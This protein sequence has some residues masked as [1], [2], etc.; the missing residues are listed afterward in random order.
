MA[1]RLPEQAERSSWDPDALA[2]LASRA[3]ARTGVRAVPPPPHD[4]GELETTLDGVRVVGRCRRSRRRLLQLLGVDVVLVPTLFVY[5]G[6]VVAAGRLGL[7]A[8]QPMI[9]AAGVGWTLLTL[10]MVSSAVLAAGLALSPATRAMTVRSRHLDLDGVRVAWEAV[11][12]VDELPDGLA[13][14]CADGRT[15][16]SP[17]LAP[18]EVRAIASLIAAHRSNPN[19]PRSGDRA[20][21]AMHRLLAAADVA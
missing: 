6:S 7:L 19:D 18:D 17:V 2:R 16:H 1:W 12:D 5:G 3:H 20:Q 21:D 9:A 11:L 13:V 8:G 15:L 10:V 14:A 4:A